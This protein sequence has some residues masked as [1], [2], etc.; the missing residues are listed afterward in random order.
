MADSLFKLSTSRCH[1]I[2][3]VTYSQA[4]SRCNSSNNNATEVMGEF[5]SSMT[6]LRVFFCNK[7]LSTV[8]VE[9]L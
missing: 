3:D 2:R 6:G 7:S 4:L 1:N 9:C 5:V 8:M